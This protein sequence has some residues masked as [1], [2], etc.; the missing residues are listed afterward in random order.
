MLYQKMRHI[1]FLK[2]TQLIQ[3]LI[4]TS[5]IITKLPHERVF[6]TRKI[7]WVK[8][9]KKRYDLLTKQRLQK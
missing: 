9:P 4:R 5:V 8:N 6:F 2:S 3:P 7:T 1:N